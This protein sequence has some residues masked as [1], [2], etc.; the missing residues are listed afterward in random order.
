MNLI[1]HPSDLS[2]RIEAPGSKSHM[3]RLLAAGLPERAST[4][5]LT[6][7]CLPRAGRRLCAAGMKR[8][9]SN[10]NTHRPSP[11]TS[12]GIST[13][14][15]KR[16]YLRGGNASS[17]SAGGD[18]ARGWGGGHRRWPWPRP[19]CRERHVVLGVAAASRHRP[20]IRSCTP[21][22]VA[23]VLSIAVM[24]FRCS[25]NGCPLFHVRD[26]IRT[27]VVHLFDGI[28]SR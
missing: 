3:Q 4:V 8:R 5:R 21:F 1:A 10:F 18:G 14:P 13:M 22:V 11:R 25:P 15:P 12:A 19:K 23:P 28:V 20:C 2:G 17:L 27:V 9:G 26:D 6:R 16:R 7:H 24:A